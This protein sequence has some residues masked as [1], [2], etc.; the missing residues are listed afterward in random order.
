[1]ANTELSMVR[2]SSQT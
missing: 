2:T 1:M